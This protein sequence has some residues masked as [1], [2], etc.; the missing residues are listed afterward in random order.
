M[1]KAEKITLVSSLADS[2]RE[3]KS[4]VLVNYTGLNVKTQQELKK[5]LKEVD[6]HMVVVKN[7]LLKRAIEL[8]KIDDKIA[9]DEILSGQTALIVGA[10]DP[11]API[12]ILGKF[13][14]ENELPKF[15]V[16]IIDGIFQDEVSLTK[17]STLPG[18]DA[19]LGQLLGALLA[20]EY[21]LI[22]TLQGNLQK[23]VY[24]L[25][26]KVKGGD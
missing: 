9:T 10:K 17:I 22:G 11:I 6:G 23:L 14:K 3:A 20:S 25:K 4:V 13:A 8:A 24:V 2:L 7:T 26:Q 1:K 15:K 12:Q 21:G 18:R 19:L 5:R 16:G